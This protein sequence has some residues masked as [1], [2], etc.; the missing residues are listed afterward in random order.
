MFSRAQ[1]QFLVKYENRNIQLNAMF[2]RG[3]FLLVKCSEHY[4]YIIITF[5]IILMMSML[6]IK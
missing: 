6:T 1:T 3:A 2:R 4:T 5:I